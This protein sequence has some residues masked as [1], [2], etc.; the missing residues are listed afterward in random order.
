M[1]LLTKS[2]TEDDNT[3]FTSVTD[4]SATNYNTLKAQ[5]Q[6]S[7]L[8]VRTGS[9]ERDFFGSMDEI[10]TSLVPDRESVRPNKKYIIWH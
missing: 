10:L 1:N 8:Q 9:S 3:A 4:L 7:D 5:K 2:D 6:N